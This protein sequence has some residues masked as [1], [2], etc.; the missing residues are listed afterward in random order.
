[1]KSFGKICLFI[2]AA[3][4]SA[5]LCSSCD[6]I[7]AALGRPTS[8]DLENMRVKLAE[9]REQQRQDSTA[10]ALADSLAA[11]A[12]DS[13]AMAAAES[14]A[15]SIPVVIPKEELTKQY[16]VIA[17]C[18]STPE[19]AIKE[20]SRIRAAGCTAAL[21]FKLRTDRF[22]VSCFGGDTCQEAE[23][24]MAELSGSEIC[25]PDLWIYNTNK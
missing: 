19:A 3:A 20:C 21:V 9:I 4:V 25:P 22:A 12:A 2:A 7:R 23:D 14:P 6:F 11:A 8:A 1:M 17:G 10:Q 13:T 16:H 15:D 5:A 24:A 18:F